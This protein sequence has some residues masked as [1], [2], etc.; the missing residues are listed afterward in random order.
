VDLYQAAILDSFAVVVCALLLWKHARLSAL[1]PAPIYLFF[2]IVFFTSRAY[3]V[4]ADSPTLFTGW[5]WGVVPI[6]EAEIA[7]AMNLSDVALASMT[8]AWIK[9]ASD[10]LRRAHNIP[11]GNAYGNPETPMLSE[12][13]IRLVA[14]VALPVGVLALISFAYLPAASAYGTPNIDLGNW[15]SSSWMMIAQS[16]AG[17][18]LLSLIYYYGFRRLYVV[19][20][21]IYLLVIALQG[22]NRF[23]LIIPA[24]YLALIWLSRTRR[25]WPPLWMVGACFAVL[26]VAIPLKDIG[27]MVQSGAPVSDIREAVANSFADV[28]EGRASDHLVLDEFACTVSLVDESHRYFFGS[29]YYPL[30]TLP[31]PRQLWSAKPAVNEYQRELSTPS[32]PMAL[33]GMVPT[34]HGESYANGGPF[35]VIIISFV[36]AYWLGGFYFAAMR[37]GYFS[38]YRFTYI[39]VACNLV[40]VFRDGLI[41]LVMFTV[42]NMMPLVAIAVLS[43]FSFRRERARNLLERSVLPSNARGVTQ[44]SA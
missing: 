41:S 1:H 34:L 37:S 3:F 13:G 12:R 43:Y 36:T 39:V 35:G 40:Q 17:L 15:S 8:A 22:F 5:G 16:W 23:R 2:H 4:L 21:C 19:P 28:T 32:R 9:V 44:K 10:D 31:V 7:W 14:A 18:V 6:S 20:L 30:L 26:I 33:S 42:V 25:R 24:I 11:R 27:W 29:L 38:V